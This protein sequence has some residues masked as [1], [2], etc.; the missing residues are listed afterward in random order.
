[1]IGGA[2]RLGRL[3]PLI[4]G[5]SDDIRGGDI[6]FEPIDLDAQLGRAVLAGAQRIAAIEAR[7]PDGEREQRARDDGTGD[8]NI[9]ARRGARRRN[10]N[11]ERRIAMVGDER[12]QTADGGYQPE[13]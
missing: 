10:D 9:D 5:R 7:E 12:E 8:W 6:F 2:I 11:G 13:H 4:R 1:L 3:G